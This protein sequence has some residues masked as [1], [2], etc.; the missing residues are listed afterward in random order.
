EPIDVVIGSGEKGQTYLYWKGDRLFELP[1]PYWATLGWVNSP[2]YRDGY[3]DFDRAIIPR[4][5]ECHAT[6]FKS[7]PPPFNRFDPVGYSLGIQCEVC[8]GP[9]ENTLHWRRRSWRGAQLPGRFRA[10]PRAY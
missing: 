10:Q 8:H 6:Y 7:Q 5:L 1:V 3:S 4:C 9:D 2:G